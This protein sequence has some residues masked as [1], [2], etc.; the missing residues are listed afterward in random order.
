[1]FLLSMIEARSV[2]LSFLDDNVG[3]YMIPTRSKGQ[4]LAVQTYQGPCQVQFR[5][6]RLDNLNTGIAPSIWWLQ[7]KR[8][9]S[10]L[11]TLEHVYS[12]KIASYYSKDP[13]ITPVSARVADI[14]DYSLA[15]ATISRGFQH[16]T[17]ANESIQIYVTSFHVYRIRPAFCGREMVPSELNQRQAAQEDILR[18]TTSESLT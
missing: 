14:Q 12:G 13:A 15:N 3:R 5:Q 18:S 8:A 11:S 4:H 7:D 9:K 17:S 1:M 16:L 2:R 6:V 10:Y